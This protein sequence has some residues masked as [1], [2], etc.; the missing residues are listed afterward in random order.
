[1]H[2]SIPAAPTSPPPSY[3]VAFDSPVNPGGGA[4]AN[5]MLPG[6]RVFANPEAF[7]KLSEYNYTE[8][9]TGKTSILAYLSMTGKN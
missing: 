5:F 8:D 4:F 2:Q 7:P 9:F 6:G 3:C 1:M